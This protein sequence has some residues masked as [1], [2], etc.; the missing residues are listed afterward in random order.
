MNK[1]KI[2]SKHPKKYKVKFTLSNGDVIELSSTR[3]NDKTTELDIDPSSH[4]AWTKKY[5]LSSDKGGMA[6]KFANKFKGMMD[7]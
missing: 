2:V 4:R 7:I 1:K 3:K 6:A 5:D